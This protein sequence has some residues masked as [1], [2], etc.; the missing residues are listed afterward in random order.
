MS[1]P[2]PVDLPSAY[3]GAR[4]LVLGAGGFIGRWVARRLTH[5]ESKVTAAVRDP[6]SFSTIARRY[7]I[8]ADV[9]SLASLDESSLRRVM[10]DA[11]PEIV[12]NLIGYGVDRGETDPGLA[13]QVNRDL[14]RHAA[15]ALARLGPGTASRPR[16]F[17]HVGSALEYGLL[18]GVATEDR[19]AEPHTLYGQSKL[20][21]TNALQDVAGSTGL[22]GLTA[23]AFTVFGSGEHQGRLLPTILSA[24]AAGTPVQLSAGLQ[25]RDFCYVDDVAEGLLRL[26]VSNA[27]PG[28]IVNLASGRL[29]S[30]REFALAAARVLGV[31]E[32]RLQ[33]GDAPVR[34]DEMRITGVSV[35]RL[36]TATG[37]VPPTDLESALVRATGFEARLTRHAL[38]DGMET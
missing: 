2:Q 13:W 4:T 26:G 12:F 33:F 16:C 35:E 7:D 27:L 5:V 21:G 8:A 11:N 17:V 3:R 24:A 10:E 22:R 25:Q 6:R 32:A 38:R 20:A 23:R 1:A 19:D 15:L 18:D 37:W 28:T 29:H 30:V 14:V 36:R 9:V 34:A 31:P